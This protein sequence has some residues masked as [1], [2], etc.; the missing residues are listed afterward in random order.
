[1]VNYIVQ[2]PNSKIPD[3]ILL[4]QK[5]R[6]YPILGLMG[7]FLGTILA[8]ISIPNNPYPAG[9]LFSSALM[10]SIGL[11][12]AP[13]VAIFRNP[14][15]ALR[16]EHIL[17]LAPIYWLL[18]DLLQGTYNLVEV[19]VLGIEGAFVAIGLFVSGIWIASLSRPW[20]LPRFL[21][22]S[23]SY[24]LDAPI[25]FRFILVFFSLG[26]FKY[27]YAC[28]FNP[29]RMIYY[30]GTNRWTAP[31]GRGQLGGWDAFLDHLSYFGYLLPTLTILLILKSQKLTAK[32]IMAIAL[33][34]F[35]AAFL[36]H[37][38]GRRII[39]V[40]FGAALICWFIQLKQIKIKHF[41]IGIICTAILLAF[42]QL[43]LEYRGVGF[44]KIIQ[45]GEVQ[46][47]HE[48][49]HVDDNFLRLAQIIDI[50]PRYHPYV[51]EKQVFY[52]LVRPI[53]R[54]FWQGKPTNPGFDLPSILGKKG[55]SLSSSVIGEWY[56]S[57]G[58]LIVFFGGWLY[59]RLA[60]CAS[61]LLIQDTQSAK[62]VYSLSTMTLFAGSRSMQ[63]LILMSYAI[64]AWIFITELVL[65]RQ[66][67][68]SV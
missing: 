45:T 58:F 57:G 2:N 41:L 17:I 34:L 33:S 43:M 18:L 32:V 15:T 22:K 53:P 3:H 62:L 65:S 21:A 59:G 44:Q 16:I 64:L 50:V 26:I 55:V 11:A 29:T 1:M 30:L 66:R 47:T 54:V 37:G 52:V 42:L 7:T 61:L 23:T 25:I 56:L 39:G 60:N 13:M 5:Y 12:I 28:N 68:K 4:S 46:L 40:I 20:K 51:Y 9:A 48:H 8:L 38:G 27:A 67:S 24:V 14:Q 63:D 6:I 31:W 10:M 49:L 35:M 36:A 19:N